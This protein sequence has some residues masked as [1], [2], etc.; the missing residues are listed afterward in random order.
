MPRPE[1]RPIATAK[2]HQTGMQTTQL[3]R[4]LHETWDEGLNEKMSKAG[5]KNVNITLVLSQLSF[6]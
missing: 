2:K 6:G 3:H 4:V 5:Q 1:M